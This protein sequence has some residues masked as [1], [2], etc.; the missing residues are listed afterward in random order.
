MIRFF[1]TLTAIALIAALGMGMGM[2][3]VSAQ[4]NI[5][6]TE[7]DSSMTDGV[8]EEIGSQLE[9]EN[10]SDELGESETETAADALDQTETIRFND[11]TRITG[12]EFND[13]QARVT[14]ESDV[15]SVAHMSDGLAGIGE[16]GAVDVPQTR[17]VLESGDTTTVTMQVTEFQN[18]HS[19]GVEVDGKAVRLST[20]IRN[21]NPLRYFGGETGLITGMVLS[22]AMSGAAALFVIYRE[23]KGV[24]EA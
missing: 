8:E 23:Q 5:S 4:D 15:R 21:D 24:I 7:N 12:W 9:D 16:E 19:V 10:E 18:G 1:R 6:E 22:V 13:G 11:H 3:A 14:I 17:Q 2:G 20:E